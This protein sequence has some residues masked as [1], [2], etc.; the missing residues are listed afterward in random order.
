MDKLEISKRFTEPRQEG[1]KRRILERLDSDVQKL[2]NLQITV[3]DLKWKV[4]ITEKSKK[5]KGIEFENVKGQLEEA[6]EA[7]TKLFDVNQKLM[8]NVEDGPLFSDGA[9]EVVSDES[10]SV[11]RR[12]LS[13]QAKEGFEKIGRLQLKVQKLQFLLLKL[14]GEKESRGSTRITERKTRVLLRDSIAMVAIEPARNARKRPSVHAYSPQPR[15]I[16][17]MEF[18]GPIVLKY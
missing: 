2:T 7:I 5:G 8:K 1:N 16:E 12:R 13:E 17:A 18:H 14:D 6:D 15:E 9:S 10:W 3:E 4:D 11:R